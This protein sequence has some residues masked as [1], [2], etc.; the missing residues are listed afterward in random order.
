M[1]KS[2]KHVCKIIFISLRKIIWKP[3]ADGEFVIESSEEKLHIS[4]C[5]R[6]ETLIKVCL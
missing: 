6:E 5:E 4:D 1:H 2:Q 3:L